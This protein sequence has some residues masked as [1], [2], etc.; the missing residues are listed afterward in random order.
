MLKWWSAVVLV[1][2]PLGMLLLSTLLPRL[3]AAWLSLLLMLLGPWLKCPSVATWGIW[4][5]FPQA[6]SCFLPTLQ[7]FFFPPMLCE[8]LPSDIVFK[9]CFQCHVNCFHLTLFWKLHFH[10]HE[11]HFHLTLFKISLTCLLSFLPLLWF[12]FV[13]LRFDVSFPRGV[14]CGV[15]HARLFAPSNPSPVGRL[16]LLFMFLH[17]V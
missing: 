2:W 4:S 16:S 1:S 9:L 3:V 6:R 17:S 11:N 7:H 10:S 12:Y 13:A 5:C 8:L 15:N 14:Q